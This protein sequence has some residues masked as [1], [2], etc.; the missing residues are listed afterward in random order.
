MPHDGTI[1]HVKLT[2]FHAFSKAG[3]AAVAAASDIP[4]VC[5][6]C[7]MKVADDAYFSQVQSLN[8]LH[9]RIPYPYG[10]ML[11]M[12][13]GIIRHGQKLLGIAGIATTQ[14]QA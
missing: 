4:H 9:A 13:R 2:A 12:I 8:V 14:L 1:Y 11:G 5:E 6:V 3:D 7:D 10:N